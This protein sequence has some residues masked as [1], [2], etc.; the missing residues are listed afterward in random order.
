[1]VWSLA[2]IKRKNEEAHDRAMRKHT[3][4]A[5]KIVDKVYGARVTKS[6][7]IEIVAKM[8]SQG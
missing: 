3:D 8:L 4:K 2:D 7:M 6:E 5:T 1:M